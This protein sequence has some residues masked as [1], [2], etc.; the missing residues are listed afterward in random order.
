MWQLASLR[1]SDQRGGLT[2]QR[3]RASESEVV[4]FITI[5]EVIH[6]HFYHILLVMLLF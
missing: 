2:R 4:S 6:D 1:E 3:E 5:S